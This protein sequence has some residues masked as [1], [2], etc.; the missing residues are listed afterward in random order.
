MWCILIE[1][2]NDVDPILIELAIKTSASIIHLYYGHGTIRV[3]KVSHLLAGAVFDK[4]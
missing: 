1:L 3:E 2:S 4:N